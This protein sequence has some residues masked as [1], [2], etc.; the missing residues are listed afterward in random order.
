M[1][2]LIKVILLFLLLHMLDLLICSIYS[3]K[4]K[5]IDGVRRKNSKLIIKQED[6]G[7][8]HIIKKKIKLLL[9]GWVMYRVKRLGTFP[10]QKYRIWML[11]HIF[12][13]DIADKVV[14]YNWNTIRAP[15]NISVG[16]GSVIG[17]QAILDGRN[18]IIIGANVN[19]STDAHIYTEQHDINDIEFRS[20]NSGGCVIIGDRAWISSHTTILP[21]VKVGNGAI[22]AAGGVATNDLDAFHIYGGV[23]AKKIGIRNEDISYDF[24]GEYLP[25]F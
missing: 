10:S 4:K 12:K 24:D 9:N 6:R 3:K 23:P 16:K 8:D 13:M 1:L 21:K 19:I 11:K 7:S 25:F 20:L 5:E 15:W 17:D 22:L 2:L 18:S 14:I